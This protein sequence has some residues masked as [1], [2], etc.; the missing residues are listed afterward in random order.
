[1]PVNAK[2][3]RN[4]PYRSSK[5]LVTRQKDTTSFRKVASGV[6][7]HFVQDQKGSGSQA[8][9]APS[10]MIKLL[11][12]GLPVQELDDLQSALDVSMARIANLLSISKATLHRRKAEG[13]LGLTESDRVVRF[14][15]LMGRAMEVFESEENA[16]R[17]LNSPQVGLGGEAPLDYARTEIGA[18]EVEDLLGRIEY[19]VY[20]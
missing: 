13:R 17:W 8:Y 20:S 9:S 18:R 19:G 4:K 6:V 10:R 12:E 11:Q 15:R 1:M 2:S 5:R 14:A 3:K 7:A 16:R